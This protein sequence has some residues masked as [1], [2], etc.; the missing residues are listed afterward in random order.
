MGKWVDKRGAVEANTIYVNGA[1]VATDTTVQLPEITF[2][3]ADFNSMGEMSIPLINA[4]EDMEATITKIGVDDNMTKLTAPG[5]KDLEIRWVQD[6]IQS[7][8]SIIPEGC[9]AHLIASPVTLH[10]GASLELGSATENEITYKVF[11]YN[12]FVNN[13]EVLLV[14]RIAHV[15]KVNGVDYSTSY[16]SLL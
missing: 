2:M 10:P 3:T 9:K 4:I 12:L 13:Q 6:R 15:L 16:D 8:A 1:L 11:R 14:D 5:K 7:D